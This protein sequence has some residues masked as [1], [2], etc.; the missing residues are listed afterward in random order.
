MSYLECW[1]IMEMESRVVFSK[2]LE[3]ENTELLLNG[4]RISIW[5]GE[6]SGDGYT[7]MVMHLVPINCTLKMIKIVNFSMYISLYMNTNKKE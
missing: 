7:T 4:Y 5:D 3:E 1:K 2:G 6:V